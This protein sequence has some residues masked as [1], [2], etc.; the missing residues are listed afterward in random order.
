MMRERPGPAS[1]AS[2][3]T[4]G[5]SQAG[6]RLLYQFAPGLGVSVRATT[7]LQSIQR[8]TEAS[9]GVR[10]QPIR[11]IPVAIT[12]ERRQWFGKTPGRSTFAVF[13]EG[14][15][16]GKSLPLGATLDGYLQAGI[17]DPKQK[18]W[19]VDGSATATRPIWGKVSGGLGVWG[20]AQ[21]GLARFEAGPRLSLSLGRGMKAHA[22]YRFKLRGNAEPGSGAVVTVAGDF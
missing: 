21:P 10:Y 18:D 19:F 14:G 15:V 4:L 20:G 8:G 1:L 17:V 7:P 12:A 3:G 9:L 22:D 6:A 16:Y 5:G 11:S 13:A 2:G